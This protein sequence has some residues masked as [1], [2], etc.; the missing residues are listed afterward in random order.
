[1]ASIF[2]DLDDTLFDHRGSASAAIAAVAERWEIG[3]PIERLEAEYHRQL[4]AMHPEVMAGRLTPDEARRR[5]VGA[6]FAC[7]AMPAPESLDEVAAHAVAAYR[8]SR[9]AAP[10]ARAVVDALLA[11]HR[12]GIISNNFRDEQIGKLHAI[13]FPDLVATLVVSEDVGAMKPDPAIFRAA[14][15]MAGVAPAEAVMVGDSW[16]ADVAGA[17]ACGMH[18]VWFARHAEGAAPDAAVPSFAS[19]EHA[20]TALA[21]ILAPFAGGTRASQSPPS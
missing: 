11:R 7:A 15:A 10:G 1:V 21:A 19:F 18:A 9:R 13:G 2:F 4:A 8:A 6:L 17:R 5:R 16:S 20:G 14:L 3:A 12:V